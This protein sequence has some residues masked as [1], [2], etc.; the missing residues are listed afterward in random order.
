ML[1]RETFERVG[2]FTTQ[3]INA[4]DHDLAFR[5]GTEP[6]FVD[7]Q[8]PVTVAV[9]RHEK[10]ATDN[11]HKTW[12]GLMYLLDREARGQY[13]GGRGRRRERR[14]LLCQH[15]RCASFD[16]V[17]GGYNKEAFILYRRTLPWHIAFGRLRY[18][19]GFPLMAGWSL[20]PFSR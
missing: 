16:L 14:Y 13:P 8:S 2:G 19:A 4:E 18:A 1:K 3:Y 9:R 5:L 11:L 7:I 15:I 17:R 20:I 6:G 10:Q 12:K